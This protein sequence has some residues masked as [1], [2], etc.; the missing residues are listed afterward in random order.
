MVKKSVMFETDQAK[1]FFKSIDLKK[2][3]ETLPEIVLSEKYIQKSEGL[4]A[5][6]SNKGLDEKLNFFKKSYKLTE[7]ID[8]I[9]L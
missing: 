1:A 7:K 4:A 8:P 2:K 9:K 3:D 5:L 6:R